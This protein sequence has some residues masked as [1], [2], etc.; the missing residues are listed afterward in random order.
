MPRGYFPIFTAYP[1][2]MRVLDDV[3]ARWSALDPLLPAPWSPAPEDTVIAVP[4][5]VGYARRFTA[6]G[7]PDPGLLWGA[8]DRFGLRALVAGDPD[9]N[10]DRDLDLLLTEWKAWIAGQPDPPGPDSTASVNW[11]SRDTRGVPALRRHGLSPYVVIAARPAGARSPAA[12]PSGVTV[13][14]AT[15]RDVDALVRL[16]LGLLHFEADFGTAYPRPEADGW[17]RAEVIRA[18]DAAEPWLWV[19]RRDGAT[20]GAVEVQRPEA[21]GW[22]ADF[23]SVRPMAYLGTLFVDPAGRGGGIGAALV[24]A[25]HRELDAAGVGVTLLHYAQVNPLSG[26]FWHRMGYRPV[27]TG[28]RAAPAG[29]LR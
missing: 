2:P 12:A 9:G 16:N 11:P 22:M 28:W 7:P 24:A 5:A 27:W 10:P 1:L 20:V 21:A 6:T 23:T 25:A 18:L 14:R 8:P 15:H 4:G 13:R 3:A 19:A 26:P 17:L 29:T